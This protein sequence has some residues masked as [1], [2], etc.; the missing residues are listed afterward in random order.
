M[1]Y[2]KNQIDENKNILSEKGLMI[3]SKEVMADDISKEEQNSI[4]NFQKEI[5]CN[6]ICEMVGNQIKRRRKNPQFSEKFLTLNF[7]F[8]PQLNR[9]KMKIKVIRQKEETINLNGIMMIC[10]KDP[11]SFK[12]KDYPKNLIERGHHLKELEIKWINHWVDVVKLV[13]PSNDLEH[14]KSIVSGLK[15]WKTR[16]KGDPMFRRIENWK[17]RKKKDRVIQTNDSWK[18]RKKKQDNSTKE[19]KKIIYTCE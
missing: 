12:E 7:Q 19:G 11:G 9:C 14:S 17:R 13:T 4:E 10:S 2:I 18:K 8:E 5:M 6:N 16:K 15:N 3:L 1:K